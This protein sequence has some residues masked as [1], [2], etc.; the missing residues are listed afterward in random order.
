MN[1]EIRPI[2]ALVFDVFG[3][4]VDWRGSLIRECQHFGRERGL[5]DVNWT[6]LVDAWRGRYQPSLE[7]VRAGRRSWTVLD[8]LHHESLLA[9]LPGFGLEGRLSAAEIDWL[10]RGWH[11][12]DPWPDTVPGLRRLHTPFLLAPLSNGNVALMA[13]LARHARLPWDCV[14]GAELARHYKPDPEVYLTAIELLRLTPGEVMLVAA[15]NYDLRHARSHGM[16]TAF[17]RRP[18]E[19]GPEQAAD[20]EAE[21]DWDYVVESLEELADA[22]TGSARSA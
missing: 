4:L 8:D 18:T 2:K 17:V 19:Y 6:G 16:S 22:L 10:V 12:L 5:D 7:E 14:L 1:G 9:L 15:H 20:L 11:R 3:T 13:N 21:E